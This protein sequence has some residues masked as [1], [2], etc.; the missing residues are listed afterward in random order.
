[1]FNRIEMP[2]SD[3]TSGRDYIGEIVKTTAKN[4]KR[5]DAAG[6]RSIPSYDTGIDRV[7]EDQ[8]APRAD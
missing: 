5:K 8:V 3:P 2:K 6:Y 4:T 1:M 7:P